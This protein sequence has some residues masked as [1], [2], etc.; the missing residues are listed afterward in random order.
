MCTSSTRS[1]NRSV[2]ISSSNSPRARRSTPGSRARRKTTVRAVARSHRARRRL[3][4]SIDII[5]P[6]SIVAR[7]L[8]SPPRARPRARLKDHARA[9]TIVRSTYHP[10][11]RVPRALL[12]STRARRRRPRSSSPVRLARVRRAHLIVESSRAIDL[13]PLAASRCVDVS[14]FSSDAGPRRVSRAMPKQKYTAF[15]VA[16]VVAALRRSCL[17]C[18]CANVYDVDARTYALRT[19]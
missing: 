16:A 7:V 12:A 17:G 9:P 14:P 19:Q 3:R 6:R 10:H 15:D 8:H 5:D 13:E 1:S 4:A 2:E 11:P 18:W